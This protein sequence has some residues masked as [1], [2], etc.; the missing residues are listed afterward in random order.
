MNAV[1]N[2]ARILQVMVS[3]Q[4]KI[5]DVCAMCG[6]HNKTFAKILRGEFPRR[7]DAFYRV[8][9]GLGIPFEEAII[10][11]THKTTERSRLYLVSDR[12]K[13]NEIA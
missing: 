8:V 5:R 2:V 1:I 12:R 11:P 6:V 13:P 3:K 9:N 4:L 7:I 10:A